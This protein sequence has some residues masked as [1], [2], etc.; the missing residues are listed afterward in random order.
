M[1]TAK[2]MENITIPESLGLSVLGML[3]VFTVL[4]FL[5]AIIYIMT[6]II[7]KTKNKQEKTISGADAPAEP[8]LPTLPPI[9]VDLQKTAATAADTGQAPITET[10]RQTARPASQLEAAELRQG[11]VVFREQPVQRRYK[12]IVDGVEYEVGAQTDETVAV[13]AAQPSP[14][15]QQQAKTIRKYRVVVDGAE[16]EVDAETDGATGKSGKEEA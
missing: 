13:R 1:P 4:V 14:A 16:Y 12:V 10:G 9:E 3:I 8:P 11:D 7:R 6:S 5:M 2:P 15:S